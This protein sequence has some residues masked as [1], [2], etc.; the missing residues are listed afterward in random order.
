[1]FEAAKFRAICYEAVKIQR[2]YSDAFPQS[3]SGKP[4]PISCRESQTTGL[5]CLPVPHLPVRRACV[6]QHHTWVTAPELGV[7]NNIYRGRR[8]GGTGG[9]E[10]VGEWRQGEPSVPEDAQSVSGPEEAVI[11]MSTYYPHAV[12]LCTKGLSS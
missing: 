9:R 1:M 4:T 11:E 10:G 3:A 8:H 12:M 6:Y 7:L 2:V 5:E